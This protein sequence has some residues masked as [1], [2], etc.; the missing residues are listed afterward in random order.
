MP[1]TTPESG[2]ASRAR[3]RTRVRPRLDPE[4]IVAAGLALSARPG[5]TALTVR[6]LG[7]ALGA[8]PTAIYRHFRGKDALMRALLE[9]LHTEALARRTVPPSPARWR[10]SLTEY[11]DITLDL[12][13]THPAIAAEA[14]TL[15]TNG[16][17]EAA[18][19]EYILEAFT[20]AGLRD[21]ALVRHY[22]VYSSYVLSQSAGIARA[23]SSRPGNG[24]WLEGPLLLDATERPLMTRLAASL[25]ELRDEEIMRL[26]VASILDAAE[27]TGGSAGGS[28]ESRA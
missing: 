8:D 25:A 15:T 2:A 23:R 7:T 28:A 6:D 13:C 3:R 4:A 21:E 12:M 5:V 18:T 20:H 10:E 19:I 27:G 11:A 1:V 26:G 17:A 22:A 14:T 24:L 16:P 9:A